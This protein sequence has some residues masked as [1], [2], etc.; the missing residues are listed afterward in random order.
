MNNILI[1]GKNTLHGEIEVQGSKN[2]VLPILA[3]TI[4]VKGVSCIRKCPKITD[5]KNMVALLK[6]IGCMV[7]WNKE[8]VYV[9]ATHVTEVRLPYDEVKS[10]RSSVLLLGALI[11]RC[12][13]ATI[14]YPGGCMIG[15]RPIDIHL[16]ALQRLGI[17]FEH[18]IGY[19][20]G[21]T[22]ELVGNSICLRF[23][24]VG[25]T[26]NV[27]LAAV[28]AKGRTRIENCAKEPEIEALCMFLK[29][30]GANIE[31]IGTSCIEII[32]VD[33][34]HDVSYELDADRI[35]AGT[36]LFSAVA[37]KGEVEI[38]NAPVH[39][40]CSTI[41]TAKRMG[42]EIRV[43]D[44]GGLR[45]RQSRNAKPLTYIHTDIYPGFPTDLQS[46]L[47]VVLTQSQ[48]ESILEER[49]FENRFH[50]KS[51]LEKMGAMIIADDRIALISG[52]MCLHGC[53]LNARDL[54]GGAALCLAGMC[55]CGETLIGNCHYIERGYEDICRDFSKLGA[56][57]CEIG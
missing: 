17:S 20:T 8:T 10:M 26:E 45:V 49:I 37:T 13:E 56:N 6:S 36:Y 16:S 50:I 31:G 41:E 28:Y 22:E 34:L 54:R 18:R 11:G 3:A 5:V 24:S 25:A 15:E 9:D 53:S 30:A 38:V 44:Y 57:I 40:M 29:N 35:V 32:G 48:G 51:E 39:F 55:A 19:L 43:M 14:G 12:K 33:E 7:V 21:Y 23:P 46:V 1:Q 27:I 42:A 47:M 4:L 2:A 52:G